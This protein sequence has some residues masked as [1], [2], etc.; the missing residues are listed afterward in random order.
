MTEPEIA[1]LEPAFAAYLGRYR[2]CFLQSAPQLILTTTAGAC[3][4]T[5][6]ERPSNPS[7]SKLEPPCEL[8]RSS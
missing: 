4:V 3:S 7:P 1:G 2:G 6:P 5:C 8:F